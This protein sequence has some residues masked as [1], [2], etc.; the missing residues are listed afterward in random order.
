MSLSLTGADRAVI[1]HCL[2]KHTLLQR[3]I[4]QSVARKLPRARVGRGGVGA[5]GVGR[6]VGGHNTRGNSWHSQEGA[7][8]AGKRVKDMGKAAGIWTG[9][10]APPQFL[11]IVSWLL[12]MGC[13]SCE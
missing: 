11:L 7:A 1:Y 4:H 2:E 5:G 13:G 10:L 9:P 6:A 12:G 3:L 8:R